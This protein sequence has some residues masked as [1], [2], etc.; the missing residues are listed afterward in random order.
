MLHCITYLVALHYFRIVLSSVLHIMSH[1]ALHIVLHIMLHCITS[2]L[3]YIFCYIAL[4]P[5]CATQ[6]IMLITGMNKLTF[7]FHSFTTQFHS[8]V[9]TTVLISA[10]P[11]ASCISMYPRFPHSF[12]PMVQIFLACLTT[13]RLFVPYLQ[14]VCFC[15]ALILFHLSHFSL[16]L[17]LIMSCFL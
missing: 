3:H 17:R 15:V 6:C 16:C 1:I 2:T 12:S 14:S 10:S 7:K 4:L 9:Y 8:L 13:N 5:H 11:L